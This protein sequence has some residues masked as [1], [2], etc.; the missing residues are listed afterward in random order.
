M[1]LLGK[2]LTLLQVF[3]LFG[4]YGFARYLP[5][6]DTI[7]GRLTFSKKIRYAL[8]RHIF[9]SIGSNVNIEH[10]ACF[11][12]GHELE[13]GDNSGLGINC[14]VPSNIKIGRD[15]MMGPN[16]CILSQNHRFE[17]TQIPMNQQGFKIGGGCVI[18]DDVWIGRDVTMTPG[19]H[20]KTGSIVG[21]CC[22]LCRDFPAYSIIG[23]NPSTLIRSRK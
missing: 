16:C 17:N 21:A 4:Y 10:K 8:C 20:L 1:R 15:V 2:Q 7:L 14:Q 9:K 5:G 3:C 13:I 22:L 23:G 12:S 11:G 18:E 6:S 19:R